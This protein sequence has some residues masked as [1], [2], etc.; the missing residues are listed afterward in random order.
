MS[1]FT[2]EEPFWV[3]V[4]V[5]YKGM[6]SALEIDLSEYKNQDYYLEVI[7]DHINIAKQVIDKQTSK[8]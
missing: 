3:K 5:D 7:K 2:E 8:E 6:H 1:E 4:T